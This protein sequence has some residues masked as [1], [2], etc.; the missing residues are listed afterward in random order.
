MILRA[1]LAVEELL[2][3]SPLP[4]K[5][6]IMTQIKKRY[7]STPGWRLGVGLTTSTLKGVV[8]KP[9]DVPRMREGKVSRQR[10]W[11]IQRR[12]RLDM[13]CKAIAAAVI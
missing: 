3:G 6:K 10:L 5:S 11:Q 7:L 1:M 13:G 12:P 9:P 8:L 2:V 4:D